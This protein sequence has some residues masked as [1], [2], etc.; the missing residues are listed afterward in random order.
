MHA[1]TGKTQTSLN[2]LSV[3]C[4]V[5]CKMPQSGQDKGKVQAVFSGPTNKSV[6]VAGMLDYMKDVI[7]IC[8]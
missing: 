2:L 5:N 3:L 6:D 4:G 7:Y 8:I 1:G